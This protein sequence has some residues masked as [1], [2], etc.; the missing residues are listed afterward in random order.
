ML[1]RDTL[2]KVGACTST[3]RRASV[4]AFTGVISLII[5]TRLLVLRYRWC[6]YLQ[7]GN[8]PLKR[9]LGSVGGHKRCAVDDPNGVVI[10]IATP[11]W[12]EYEEEVNCPQPTAKATQPTA[13]APQPTAKAGSVE[14]ACVISVTATLVMSVS[15]LL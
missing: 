14:R 2:D 15:F 10:N 12:N 5:N 7:S 1:R 8:L 9:P 3:T 13:K 4:L 6:R 11:G